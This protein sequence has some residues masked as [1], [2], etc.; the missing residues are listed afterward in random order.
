[1]IKATKN[2]DWLVIE[3]LSQ[4]FDKDPMFNLMIKQ[5]KKRKQRIYDSLM[6]CVKYT[7]IL[8][9]IYLSDDRKGCALI[10]Y[11]EKQKYNLR[12][13]WLDL[14]TIAKSFDIKGTLKFFDYEKTI[15]GKWPKE[16]FLYI[17]FIGVY[18]DYNNNGTGSSLLKQVIELADESSLAVCLETCGQKNL[19]WY[20]R[21]GFEVYDHADFGFQTYFMKL[22]EAGAGS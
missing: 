15:H 17:W 2:D 5:D 6:Y 1:M 10:T 19:T 3:I 16:K 4:S 20:E 11:S 12:L 9:E 22:P 14:R 7:R 8:G 21:F 13:L 18:P